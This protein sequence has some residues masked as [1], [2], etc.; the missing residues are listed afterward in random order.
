MY[1]FNEKF[2]SF[3]F[4]RYKGLCDTLSYKPLL[5]SKT[6]KYI[7]LLVALISSN[8]YS[9]VIGPAQLEVLGEFGFTLEE[10]SSDIYE[11]SNEIHIKAPLIYKDRKFE[12]GI[13]TV[14]LNG[15]IV[16]KSAHSYLNED[17]VPE[18]LGYVS[19]KQGFT[20]KVTFL[21][22]EGKCKAYEFSATNEIKKP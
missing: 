1:D 13:F 8:T 3:A 6:M 4:P 20:Y 11:S 14:F 22:G 18:F 7:L 16:S 17:G 10:T 19:N 5:W 15:K 21:Y 2:S 9:C 12:L